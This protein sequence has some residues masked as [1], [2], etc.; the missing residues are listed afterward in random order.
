MVIQV[1]L[2]AIHFQI[3]SWHKLNY[4]QKKRTISN[5]NSYS[6][7]DCKYSL[8]KLSFICDKNWFFVLVRWR[9]GH[10]TFGIF[11]HSIGQTDTD[12]ISIYRCRSQWS[13]QT[14]LLSI[15]IIYSP[16]RLDKLRETLVSFKL[17]I[18]YRI[19]KLLL[20]LF[21][22]LEQQFCQC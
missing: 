4:L 9:G 13:I 17:N 7:K 8:I 6:S 21:E 16:L 20:S 2:W 22:T 14:R 18:F 15:L 11:R 19:V 1:L 12:T 5:W 10:G 3:K